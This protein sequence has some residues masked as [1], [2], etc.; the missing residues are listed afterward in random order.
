MKRL[1]VFLF[2]VAFASPA[3]SQEWV[4]LDDVDL[5]TP[6]ASNADLRRIWAA[7]I[8]RNDRFFVEVVKSPPAPGRSAPAF[9]ASRRI[10]TPDGD[11]IVSSLLT[12]AGCDT[13]ANDAESGAT[14]ARC[15]VRTAFRSVGVKDFLVLE[16]RMGCY[17]EVDSD[18]RDPKKRERTGVF[19]I[20][21]GETVEVAA[22]DGG[23]RLQQ[24]DLVMKG[25]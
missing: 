25:R 18:E 5:T 6:T 9:A 22:A 14:F 15:P 13:G 20:R 12:G 10:V 17:I 24:C 7:E 8:A 1:A 11:L 23:K 19:A 4:R 16:T 21:R 2:A 3:L